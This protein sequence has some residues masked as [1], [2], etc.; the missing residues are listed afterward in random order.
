M[1]IS[2]PNVNYFGLK[3]N[4][5]NTG[6]FSS[7]LVKS[8]KLLIGED[9]FKP[10]VVKF[11]TMAEEVDKLIFWRNLRRVCTYISVVQRY[12]GLNNLLF[13]NVVFYS[14]RSNIENLREKAE[15]I[16]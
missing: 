5:L 3:S 4:A 8:E 11:I 6:I 7:Q 2:S 1:K 9:R 13:K 14:F 16:W 10:W 15:S 12:I